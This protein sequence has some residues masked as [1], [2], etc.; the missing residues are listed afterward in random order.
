MILKKLKKFEKNT[1]GADCTKLMILTSV[2]LTT[3]GAT[4][5]DCMMS[6]YV[7]MLKGRISLAIWVPH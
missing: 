4:D 2:M 1:K 6:I 5:G 3:L 7:A